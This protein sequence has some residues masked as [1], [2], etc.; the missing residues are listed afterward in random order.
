GC[1]NVSFH[2]GDPAGM[3]FD[4]PF[5][6]AIGRFVLQ[7]QPDPAAMLRSL[8]AHLRPGG[9]VVFHEP[10]WQSACSYPAVPTYDLCCAWV[11]DALRSSGADT[12]MGIKLYST[13]LAAGLAA[14]SLRVEAVVGGGA[15]GSDALRLVADLA[16]TLSP[17]IRRLGYP[18]PD[19]ADG[20]TLL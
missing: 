10:D 15:A 5:D 12:R 18:I 11:V 17:V 2:E 3:A 7:F 8:A 9:I 13:F 4:Q 1:R 19:G 20:E 14:P 16:E 6:A